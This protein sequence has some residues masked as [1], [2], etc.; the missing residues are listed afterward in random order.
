MECMFN[1]ATKPDDKGLRK[2]APGIRGLDEITGGGLPAGPPTLVCGGTGS[3]SS[4]ADRSK[5][6]SAPS[7]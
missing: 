3:G 1:P 2:S 4:L 7:G 6:D 5:W